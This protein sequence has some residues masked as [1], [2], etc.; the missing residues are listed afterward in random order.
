MLVK[1]MIE[2]VYFN[3]ID[4]L[5]NKCIEARKARPKAIEIVEMWKPCYLNDKERKR[6]M[7]L[8]ILRVD[9]YWDK[10][11]F[12]IGD[13]NL[14]KQVYDELTQFNREITPLEKFHASF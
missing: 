12:K 1:D 9:G 2:R 8:E 11:Y 7:H 4:E 14:A 6:E 5:K 3:N 10:I 13:E